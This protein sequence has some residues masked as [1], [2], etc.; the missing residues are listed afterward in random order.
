MSTTDV[1]PDQP[2]PEAQGMTESM[3]VIAP[4][5]VPT[6]RDEGDDHKGDDHKGDDHKGDPS[7]RLQ[8]T[9]KIE[10]YFESIDAT[11]R[12]EV[13]P[14]SDLEEKILSNPQVEVVPEVE[15]DQTN[16]FDD[17]LARMYAPI[18]LFHKNE[19]CFP[20]SI[21]R[22]LS[23]SKVQRKTGEVLLEGKTPTPTDLY[24]L[25][26]LGEKDLCLRF[27]GDIQEIRGQSTHHTV[28][29]HVIHLP[30]GKMRIVYFY[31]MSHTEPYKLFG[32]LCPLN[33]WAHLA[34]LKFIMVEL[35]QVGQVGQV[36]N[37]R[38]YIPERMYLGAHGYYG[39]QWISG[40]Q[41]TIYSTKGDHSFYPDHGLHPRIFCAV[42]ECILDTTESSACSACH[43]CSACS[44]CTG[45]GP[46][47]PSYA[48]PVIPS[49]N[50]NS[51]G[52]LPEHG[53]VYFPGQMNTEGIN[54]P[55]N[56]SWWSGDVPEESNTWW[57]RLLCPKFW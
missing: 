31:L 27:T 36:G 43:G 57:K 5:G 6:P 14:E 10:K 56:Q 22:Y 51:P 39:G 25:Y 45:I 17:T 35:G 32:C 48:V 50:E 2:N 7:P 9:E 49:R 23:I 54:S 37:E 33:Q 41:R 15:R 29:T 34:D 46:Y 53:W 20:I 47:T 19:T 16:D 24:N 28:Y 38:S 4:D 52:F 12:E 3:V 13:H 30:N 8:W 44:G 11:A 1:S 42:C 55:A 21:D 40:F 26:R 18:L